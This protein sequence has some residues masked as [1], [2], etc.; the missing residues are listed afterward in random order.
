[1]IG[2][3]LGDTLN[4]RNVIARAYGLFELKLD[5]VPALGRHNGL[6]FVELFHSRLNLCRMAGSRFEARDERLLFGE[7]RLLTGVMG[8]VLRRRHRALF[9]VK[10]VVARICRDVTAVNFDNLGHDAI[11]KLTIMRRD[12]QRT[13]EVAQKIFEPDNG[14]DVQVVSG[15]IE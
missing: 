4:D 6:D 10:I 14:F 9:F 5:D 8:F 12:D 2:V 1:M 13:I 7:H 3:S 15:L 11:Q